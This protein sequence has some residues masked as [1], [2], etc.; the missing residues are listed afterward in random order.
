MDEWRDQYGKNQTKTVKETQCQ[1][2]RVGKA[3]PVVRDQEGLHGVDGLWAKHW[4]I[5]MCGNKLFQTEGAPGAKEQKCIQGLW[6][7]HRTRHAA[8][9]WTSSLRLHGS[10]RLTSTHPPLFSKVFL[11]FLSTLST[12]LLPTFPNH[13]VPTTVIAYQRLLVVPKYPVSPSSRTC[14]FL[15]GTWLPRIKIT[16]LNLP[17]GQVD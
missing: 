16:F 1:E 15:T 4:R 11:I 8:V 5:S 7:N 13:F 17:Y 14:H 9:F 3:I 12:V 10:L 2:F 6:E